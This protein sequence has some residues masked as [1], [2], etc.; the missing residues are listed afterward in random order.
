MLIIERT[1]E[2]PSVEVVEEE[3]TMRFNLIVPPKKVPAHMT[4]ER[5][6]VI[7][8]LLKAVGFWVPS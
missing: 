8:D 3:D 6:K 1:S 5:E 7:I 2:G 4:P